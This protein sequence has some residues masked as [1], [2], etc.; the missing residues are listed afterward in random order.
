MN[1]N[2]A[3]L[4]KTGKITSGFRYAMA[5]GNWGV[6]KSSSQ[7]GV[8]QALNRMTM[9]SA[10]ANLRRLHTPICRDGKVPKPRRGTQRALV[11]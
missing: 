5:T 11:G 7:N 8:A 1:M 6:Q 9:G 4:V 3:V 2:L 10:I